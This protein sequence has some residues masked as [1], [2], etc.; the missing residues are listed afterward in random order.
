MDRRAGPGAPPRVGDGRPEVPTVWERARPGPAVAAIDSIGDDTEPIVGSVPSVR[1]TISSD[2]RGLCHQRGSQS[3]A[4]DHTADSAVGDSTHSRSGNWGR[5]GRCRPGHC[6][7]AA[8][9]PTIRPLGPLKHAFDLAPPPPFARSINQYP[10]YEIPVRE[11]GSPAPAPVGCRFDRG[12]AS[13]TLEGQR[14]R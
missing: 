9:P 8:I 13:S 1:V 3:G 10:R 4:S 11:I 7:V 12:A 2:N 5:H 14:R 6:P